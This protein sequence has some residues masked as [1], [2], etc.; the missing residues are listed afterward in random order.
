M[1]G[2]KK[3]HPLAGAAYFLAVILI[4]A[5]LQ[6]PFF[7]AVS[8]IFSL[9]TA[10]NVSGRKILKL[11]FIIVPFYILSCVINLLF[12]NAGITVLFYLPTGNAATLETLI[13]S[14]NSGAMMTALVMWFVCITEIMTSEKIVYLFGRIAPRLGLLISMI[15]RFVPI[16]IRRINDTAHAQKFIGCDIYSGNIINRVKNAFKVLSVAIA[17]SAEGAAHTAVSMKGRGYGIKGV[18]RTS[19]TVYYFAAK[20]AVTVAVVLISSAVI[21]AGTCAGW[22]DY[23]FYPYFFAKADM[24]TLILLIAWTLLCALPLAINIYESKVRQVDTI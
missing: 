21:I 6:S 9:L 23:H 3:Y 12:N 22:A 24:F 20:E 1:R 10:I 16:L 8:F 13:Y 4:T 19:Y 18:R 7:I 11:L 17:A 5:F 14:L 2:F 15:L